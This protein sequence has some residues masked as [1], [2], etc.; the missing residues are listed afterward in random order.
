MIDSGMFAFRK[1]SILSRIISEL[2]KTIDI[3]MTVGLDQLTISIPRYNNKLVGRIY[4][5]LKL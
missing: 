3:P 2:D 4:F 5:L 1:R